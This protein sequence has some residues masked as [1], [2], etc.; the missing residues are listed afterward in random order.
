[1]FLFIENV[2]NICISFSEFLKI[3]FATNPPNNGSS[4]YRSDL[5]VIQKWSSLK[6]FIILFKANT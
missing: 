5:Y 4:K 3:A 1:M 2:I 6:L